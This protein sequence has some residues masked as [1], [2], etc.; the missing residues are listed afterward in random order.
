MTLFPI[1]TKVIRTTGKYTSRH[2]KLTYSTAPPLQRQVNNPRTTQCSISHRAWILR[3][4][5]LGIDIQRKRTV[6][7]RPNI[8]ICWIDRV[9]VITCLQGRAQEGMISRN[10]VQTCL[11][12]S[13][14]YLYQSC[15]TYFQRNNIFY[16]HLP[17]QHPY[18][19]TRC[20]WCSQDY[21]IGRQQG[22]EYRDWSGSS[23]ESQ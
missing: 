14:W 13:S 18:L 4:P 6:A 10:S 3:Q 23:F 8:R 9:R 2:T 12:V 21:Y 11:L 22:I 15:Q 17:L 16:G 19:R 1:P 20:S 7:C 5:D